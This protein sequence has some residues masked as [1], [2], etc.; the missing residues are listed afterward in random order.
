V[1]GAIVLAGVPVGETASLTGALRS[2]LGNS[3]EPFARAF[4]LAAGCF[5][6]TLV[7]MALLE[8]KPLK[9]GEA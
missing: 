2:A 5:A 6:V 9:A 7:C 8:E 4:Y 1:F 3:A